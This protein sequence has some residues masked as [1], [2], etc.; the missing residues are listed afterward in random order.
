MIAEMLQRN[1][2]DSFLRYAYALEHEKNGDLVKAI[3]IIAA[4]LERDSEYLGAYYKLG[5]LHEAQG[6]LEEAITV[7]KRGRKLAISKKDAKTQGEL[8]EALMIL[9]AD[10]D[11]W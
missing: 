11:I 5:K 1:P 10:D 3:E 9:D 2:D 4:L 8:T 6:N 7:Y